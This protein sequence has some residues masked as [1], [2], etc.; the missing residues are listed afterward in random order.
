[1]LAIERERPQ[2]IERLRIEVGR[3]S[4]DCRPDDDHRVE[5]LAAGAQQRER[6]LLVEEARAAKRHARAEQALV[7][8]R[9]GERPAALHRPD[10]Q[11]PAPQLVQVAQRRIGAHEH[12]QRLRVQRHHDAQAVA[13]ELVARGL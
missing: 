4:A 12:V 11:V 13:A 7:E 6:V 10:V 9:A 2:R 5:R 1:M 8:H 3:P